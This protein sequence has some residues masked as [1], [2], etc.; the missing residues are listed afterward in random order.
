MQFLLDCGLGI[1]VFDR[2]Q[3]MFILLRSY[4]IYLSSLE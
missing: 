1:V 4:I 3:N 2:L